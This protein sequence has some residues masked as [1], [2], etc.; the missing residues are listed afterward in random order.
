MISTVE[1]Q[2]FH[3]PR[4]ADLQPTIYDDWR[5]RIEDAVSRSEC[6][7][8]IDPKPG[9]MIT[10]VPDTEDHSN[11]TREQ[12]E[13]RVKAKIERREKMVADELEKL[14]AKK[15]EDDKEKHWT[16]KLRPWP[17]AVGSLYMEKL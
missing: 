11:E 13:A 1:C 3:I 16:D 4:W 8:W 5:K 10:A 9:S 17:G 7:K 15:K 12:Y 14:T 2:L 6:W